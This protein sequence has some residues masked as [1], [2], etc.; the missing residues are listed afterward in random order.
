MSKIKKKTFSFRLNV[1]SFFLDMGD[2]VSELN[3]DEKLM[4][5]KVKEEEDIS[6]SEFVKK[7]FPDLP[8]KMKY[9][10]DGFELFSMDGPSFSPSLFLT[11]HSMTFSHTIILLSA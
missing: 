11:S 5:V 6:K 10:E 4:Q 3:S 8:K 1:M 2:N 9:S 7:I